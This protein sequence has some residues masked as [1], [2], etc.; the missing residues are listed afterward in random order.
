MKIL[1]INTTVNT[2]STGRIA[3]EIGQT[4]QQYGHESYIA[5]KSLG[6]AGSSSKLIRIGSKM[7]VYMH[8]LKTRIFDRHGFGSTQATQRFL[9]RVKEINPDVIGLHNLHGYYLNIELLFNYLKEIQKP[10]V[11]T[12]HDCWPF[13]GHCSFFDY[14]SCEKWKTECYDCPL[15]D[16]YPASWFLDN[17]KKNFHQ[18]RE[19]F[20]GVDNLTIVTPSHWLANL[21]EQSFLSEYPVEVIHNGIDLEQFHPVNTKD[22]MMQYKLTGKKVLLGVA[23][24]WDRRKG[25]KYFVELAKRLNDDFRIILIGL[26]GD[27]NHELPENI[28]AVPRTE[29][30]DE[31][32][33][34]YSVADLFVNP[35]LVDNFPTTN[36]EALA[37]GTPVVTFNTGGSPEAIDGKTGWVV[38]KSNTDELYNSIQKYFKNDLKINSDYCRE[39]CMQLF[40]K[41]DRYKDYLNLYR[42]KIEEHEYIIH[43]NRMA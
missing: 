2:T 10:V 7:D 24:V 22:I 37:C 12:L 4:L 29:D 32:V 13:T 18:K 16:K 41:E 1:Q 27:S 26:S 28:I 17:S 9:E 14:V 34:F 11:W 19:L 3:E 5:Y 33:S 25:L 35:T 15:S 38:E 31:L 23:S 36:L 43:N 20:N 30:I 42:S 39:R 6:P 8:G 40:N 21:V